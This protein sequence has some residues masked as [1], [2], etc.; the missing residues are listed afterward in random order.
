MCRFLIL[1]LREI[2]QICAIECITVNISMKCL[3]TLV[4][5]FYFCRG[6]LPLGQILKSIKIKINPGFVAFFIPELDD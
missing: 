6:W 2:V 4:F 1:N 3:Q 5:T